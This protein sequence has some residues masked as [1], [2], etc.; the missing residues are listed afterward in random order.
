MVT[1]PQRQLEALHILARALATGEF[2]ART[3]LGRACAAV[4]EAFSFERVGI[5]RYVPS[6]R[7]LIPFVAHGLSAAEQAALPA[8]LPIEHFS[9]FERAL[10]TGT[11][12]FVADPGGERAL[13][14]PR[15]HCRCTSRR[16]TSREGYPSI[17]PE[18]ADEG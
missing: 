18:V 2:R 15:R 16:T 17:N 6:S 8:A 3:V 10:A 11:P 13:S 1:K 12:I 9:A 4:A 5:V 14:D 7:V